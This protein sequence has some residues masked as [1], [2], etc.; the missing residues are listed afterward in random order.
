MS[1]MFCIHNLEC[2]Q[3]NIVVF[4]N[5]I[6]LVICILILII[7]TV[8]YSFELSRESLLKTL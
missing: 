2:S 8:Y 5:I 7:Y 3:S 6:E 4:N 1:Y